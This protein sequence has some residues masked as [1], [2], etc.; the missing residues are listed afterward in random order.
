VKTIKN[1][2]FRSL[3]VPERRARLKN[4]LEQRAGCEV[5]SDLIDGIVNAVDIGRQYNITVFSDLSAYHLA[6]SNVMNGAPNGSV[7]L[8]YDTDRENDIW[9]PTA[10][11]LKYKAMRGF[12]SP[13]RRILLYAPRNA[14]RKR[15]AI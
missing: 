9:A 4:I 7:K 5:N 13:R 8:L 10:M 3:R 14:Q 6:A 12:K 1:K 11:V 15:G 2:E